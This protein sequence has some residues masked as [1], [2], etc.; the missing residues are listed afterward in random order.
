ME[1]ANDR[2]VTDIQTM[3]VRPSDLTGE[4]ER[5]GEALGEC[6][7]SQEGGAIIRIQ[8]ADTARFP[9][10]EG[11]TL[12]ER[13]IDQLAGK[14]AQL[15]ATGFLRMSDPQIAARQFMV[16]TTAEA[17]NMSGYGRRP[18]SRGALRTIVK[19]GVETFLAAF[20]RREKD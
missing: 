6:V 15:I 11:N 4:L 14:L 9:E 16:L 13:H 7:A 2:I 8:V 1:R 3:D 17:L 12:R 18:L 5:L 10:L 20:G 19:A